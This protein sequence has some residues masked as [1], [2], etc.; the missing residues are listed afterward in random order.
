MID[1]IIIIFFI[2]IFFISKV[3]LISVVWN[4]DL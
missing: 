2:P 3:Y 1:T 4:N